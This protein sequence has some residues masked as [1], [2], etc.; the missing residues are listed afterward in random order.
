MLF[1]DT[2]SHLQIVYL[3]IGHFLYYWD[4]QTCERRGWL[5]LWVARVMGG[6]CLKEIAKLICTALLQ[7]LNLLCI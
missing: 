2:F 4:S 6:C 5:E 1:P 3:S 7:L